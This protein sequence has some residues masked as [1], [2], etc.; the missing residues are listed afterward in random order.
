MNKY[1]IVINKVEDQSA[2]DELSNSLELEF[3]NH[4]DLF[5]IMEF[6]KN[7]PHF[8]D[9]QE[10]QKFSLGLKLFSGVM[11]KNKDSELFKEFLPAFAVF[12]KKLKEKNRER[13][14]Y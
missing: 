9:E 11:F 3:E 6:A 14:I 8:N 1:R 12:M 13:R 5:K 2:S 7:S 10:A 4:D